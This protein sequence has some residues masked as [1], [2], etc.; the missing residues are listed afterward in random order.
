VRVDP[1]ERFAVPRELRQEL[2]GRQDDRG[3]QL[4]ALFS[5]QVLS[6]NQ[7]FVVDLRFREGK[8][9]VDLIRATA[10][11][12]APHAAGDSTDK[13]RHRSWLRVGRGGQPVLVE[14]HEIVATDASLRG[15]VSADELLTLSLTAELIA[16]T[17]FLQF[18]T[19]MTAE[20]LVSLVTEAAE[21]EGIALPRLSAAGVC[22]N[23][24]QSVQE[25]VEIHGYNAATG[26]PRAT[27][28]AF[29]RGS[30]FVI[31]A[32]VTEDSAARAHLAGLRNALIS[33]QKASVPLGERIADGF[34]RFQVDLSL[35]ASAYWKMPVGGED[36]P[37]VPPSA[38]PRT[39]WR[40]R[41]LMDLE[42]AR[43]ETIRK[44]KSEGIVVVYPDN[45]KTSLPT[46]TQWQWL[47]Q[48]ARKCD[49]P[50]AWDR[51][52]KSLDQHS[53][54]KAGR[55]WLGW[56]ERLRKAIEEYAVNEHKRWFIE[57]FAVWAVI[58]LRKLK[59]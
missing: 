32:D 24:R 51:L 18:R 10:P 2:Q 26:L 46:I 20:G 30:V 33:L 54:I 29:K 27:A 12:W 36:K 44:D 25:T 4:D 5:Q 19:E 47:R 3:S 1:K 8:D 59:K 23:R 21:S 37:G 42:Q 56:S 16:R 22:V 31:E 35:H 45:P 39:N 40:E 58:E 55:A 48:E 53:E 15:P 7:Y 13:E 43:P 52:W 57:Q 6:D 34:G 28:T 11:L 41:V 17:P 9:A 49:D 50:V 38:I 14:R